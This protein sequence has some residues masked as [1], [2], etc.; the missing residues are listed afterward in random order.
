VRGE[1]LAIVV[2]ACVER[3]HDVEPGSALEGGHSRSLA[4]ASAAKR[5][6]SFFAPAKSA[7]GELAV[8]LAGR[9]LDAEHARV[10]FELGCSEE[11]RRA[12]RDVSTGDGSSGAPPLGGRGARRAGPTRRLVPLGDATK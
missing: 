4:A 3:G 5:M 1:L 11:A 12:I 9:S 2:R 8:G 10:G 6:R 7:P